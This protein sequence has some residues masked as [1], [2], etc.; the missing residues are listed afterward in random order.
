M[1]PLRTVV[2]TSSEIDW[3]PISSHPGLY[4]REIVNAEEADL[5]GIRMSSILW[6][7]IEVGGAVLPH[8]HNVVEIIHIT[9]GKVLLLCNGEWKSYQAGDTFHVPAQVIHSVMNDDINPTEQLSIFVPCDTDAPQNRFF[10]T[11][12]VDVPLPSSQKRGMIEK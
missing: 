4:H 8:Y 3:A 6:E 1:S 11:I 5:M 12:K 9:K 10:E 2:K 7:K